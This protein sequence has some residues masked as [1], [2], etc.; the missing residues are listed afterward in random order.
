VKDDKEGWLDNLLSTHPPLRR[1]IE[2][3]RAMAG[4]SAAATSPSAAS[5]A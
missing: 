4:G 5:Q 3:L 1:R 2:R